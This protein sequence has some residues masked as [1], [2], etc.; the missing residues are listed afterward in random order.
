VFCSLAIATSIANDRS[1]LKEE[2]MMGWA[3]AGFALSTI[4][5]AQF[6]AGCG[7][8]DP[9]APKMELQAR[10]QSMI[11]GMQAELKGQFE[12]E[13]EG[14]DL[15]A[16]LDNA[17]VPMGTSISF[18][19]VTG[20]GSTP[21]AAPQ[22]MPGQMQSIASFELKSETG[23][24]VPNVVSGNKLEAREGAMPSGMADCGAPLLMSAIFQPD[25]NAPNG[26]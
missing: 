19:L 18:C 8:S 1:D 24:A 25:M 20:S 3:K 2:A 23:Q 9:A 21:L 15:M 6:L 26:R 16:E 12:I 13:M 17:N 5:L 7:S 14:R 22:T 4:A 11:D 10:A